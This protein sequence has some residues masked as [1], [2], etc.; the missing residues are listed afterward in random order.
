MLTT[1]SNIDERFAKNNGMPSAAEWLTNE[2]VARQSG[3]VETLYKTS[4]TDLPAVDQDK[5]DESLAEERHGETEG[6]RL[7][8]AVQPSP[9]L[10]HSAA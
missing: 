3:G 10:L 8:K 7:T 9:C 2:P 4:S 6:E 1:I 5:S